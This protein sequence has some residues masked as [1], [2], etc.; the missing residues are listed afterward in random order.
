MSAFKNVSST[1]YKWATSIFILV[2]LSSALLYSIGFRTFA[3]YDWFLSFCVMTCIFLNVS[4]STISFF[5]VVNC[6][7]V[8]V[9]VYA[10]VLLL[11][12]VRVFYVHGMCLYVCIVIYM[13]VLCMWYVQHVF[14][15]LSLFTYMWYVVLCCMCVYM[16][17][18]YMQW[19]L[20]VVPGV[21]VYLWVYSGDQIN[22]LSSSSV[23]G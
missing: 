11:Q 5:Y 21:Y 1:S 22:F 9:C 15:R 17:V 16:C 20:C 23:S 10:C 8:C 14:V 19:V 13:C 6:V 2:S 18:C 4:A 7:Y 3:F 12:D